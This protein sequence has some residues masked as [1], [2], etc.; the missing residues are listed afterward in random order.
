M[1]HPGERAV[2]E[3]A[4]VTD[5]ADRMLG[6]QD[7]VIPPIASEFLAEQ[8]WIVLGAADARRTACGRARSTASPAS[9]RRRTSRPCTSPRS[10]CPAIRSRA[11]KAPSARSPSS[12][13]PAAGCGS[14]GRRARPRT[15]S[16]SR[17]SRSTGTARSTSRRG[18]RCPTARHRSASSRASNSSPRADTAFVATRAPEGTDASH[19]GGSPGLPARRRRHRELA[20]LP[21]Q[22]DVQHARQPRRRPGLRADGGRPRRRHDALPHRRGDDRRRPARHAADPGRDP[23]R[24]RRAAALVAGA[25]RA[26]TRAAPEAAGAPR[27]AATRRPAR[28]PAARSDAARRAR[29]TTSRRSRS[30]VGERSTRVLAERAQ[31]AS[32]LPVHVTRAGRAEQLDLQPIQ[33]G[34]DLALVGHL[35]DQP[36]GQLL[37]PGRRIG[38]GVAQ[39]Q[40]DAGDP[41]DLP[42]RRPLQRG[43]Q[44]VVLGGEVP[45]RRG[46][47]DLRLAATRRWVTAAM[48]SRATIR[49]VAT[50][51]A[52][53][54]CLEAS[55]RTDTHRIVQVRSYL[56][57]QYARTSFPGA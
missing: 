48:P 34:R 50:T 30:G 38:I 45:R 14:T 16:R 32:P 21:G 1:W 20:G 46:E 6:S 51:I 42:L 26:A 8:P 57:G 12:R 17:S 7:P 49:T 36:V 37:G 22:R 28:R 10:R 27:R 3:L 39:A 40:G 9:S 35:P 55:A 18:T 31:A 19:R 23:A 13:P 15:A 53:R 54:T 56:R 29:T 5:R 25:R 2:Q 52:S 43:L 11:S 4:G 33:G 47:R 24:P 41:P 44:D